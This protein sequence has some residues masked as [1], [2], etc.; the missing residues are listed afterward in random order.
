MTCERVAHTNLSKHGSAISRLIDLLTPLYALQLA[1]TLIPI[2]LKEAG[3]I[4]FEIENSLMGSPAAVN[5]ILKLPSG[6]Y[7]H[8]AGWSDFTITKTLS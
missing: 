4:N 1:G 7:T 3:V 8:F 6:K 5:Y 2:I